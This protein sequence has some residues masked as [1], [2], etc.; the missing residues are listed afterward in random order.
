MF[1]NNIRGSRAAPAWGFMA[2]FAM[3][4][5]GLAL[6]ASPAAA[7]PFAYV[8]NE[9]D[10]TVSVIDTATNKVVAR[11]DGGGEGA[12][13]E[14]DRLCNGIVAMDSVPERYHDAWLAGH[15]HAPVEFDRI[16]PGGTRF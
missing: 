10:N 12:D 1:S 3:L 5:M 7:A 9:S 14:R 15:D 11:R 2:L 8:T 6:M 16:T 4:A 13:M